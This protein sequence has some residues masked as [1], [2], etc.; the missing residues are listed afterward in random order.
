MYKRKAKTSNP[1][2]RQRRDG[3]PVRRTS[4]SSGGYPKSSNTNMALFQKGG[5]TE[6]KFLDTTQNASFP[7]GQAVATLTLLN[8]IA[9]GT[10]AS[11]RVGGR[12][13]VKSVQFRGNF[14]SGGSATGV[15]PLRVKIIYD[16]ESNGAAPNATDI[17]NQDL[18]YGLNNLLNAGRFIT[19]FDETFEPI[20]G[21]GTS[22][23]PGNYQAQ[24]IEGYKKIS[25]PVKYNAGT[26]GTV[27][28]IS[29]GSIYALTWSN[30][31]ATGGIG[32]GDEML[33]RIR[34]TDI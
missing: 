5:S 34:Y 17:M 10:S 26:A 9:P 8:G 20:V 11:Q 13:D 31:T 19:L 25:L 12:I 23:S 24:V 27:A 33:F 15:T 3:S 30:G 29:S 2:K 1:A 16:K 32:F 14:Q 6:K 18:I 28:D 7:S 4:S 22:G 21:P